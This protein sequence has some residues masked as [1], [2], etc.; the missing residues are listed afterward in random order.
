MSEYSYR[1]AQTSVVPDF[2][3]FANVVVERYF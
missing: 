1:T 3:S 2:K